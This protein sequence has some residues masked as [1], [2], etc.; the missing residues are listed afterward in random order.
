MSVRPHYAQAM[1]S[2]VKRFEFRRVRVSVSTGDRVL[3]YESA[4]VALVTGEFNVGQ[5][6]IGTP[7]ELGTIEQDVTIREAV[8]GYLG[9][10]P[11]GTAIQI[12]N[13][14]RWERPLGISE[15]TPGRRP[16]QSY[17]FLSQ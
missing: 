8:R 5:V 10:A 16:P 3:V 14:T 13:P 15:L 7:A 12:L 6:I 17:S 1:F 11:Q 9:G 4:P 2:G